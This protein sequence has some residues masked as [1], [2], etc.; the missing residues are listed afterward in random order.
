M[1]AGNGE[2]YVGY[3][4]KAPPR[5]GRFLV[6]VTAA[7]LAAGAVIAVALLYSQQ[8]FDH[9]Y[10]EYG[11]Y[12]GYQ[13]VLERRPYPALLT[14]GIRYLLVAPGKHGADELLAAA[15]EGSQIR[16]EASVIRNGENRMLEVLPGSLNVTN[17]QTAAAP[18]A[19]DLGVVVL[20]GEIVDSKCYFGVMNP[21]RGKVHRDC[22]AR[23][24]RGGIPPAFLVRDRAGKAKVIV[25][26]ASTH[27]VERIAEPV[28][29]RGRLRESLGTL[30]LE[31][32]E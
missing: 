18:A 19:R 3:W 29:I 7:I 10:F 9:S 21:G 30:F 15:G 1:S 27:L 26:E 28:T 25:L 8:P 16:L 6:R 14:G 23:C 20:T 31:A 22:A 5:L 11:Q 17:P 2:F 12:R 4:E 24:I 13:G 32:Q